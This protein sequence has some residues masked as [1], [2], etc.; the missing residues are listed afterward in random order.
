M[1]NSFGSN[2]SS[3]RR[4]AGVSQETLAEQIGVSRQAVSNW[5]RDLSEP[6]I[7]TINKISEFLH[8]PVSDLMGSPASGGTNGEAVKIRPAL[9]VISV[10]LAVVH[11]VLG[12]CGYV[13][14]F[15]AVFLPVMCAF[16][17]SII[18]IAFTTMIKSNHYDMLA[19]FDPKKDSIPKTQLQMQWIA[20]L[21]G[22]T[23]IL[24]ELVFMPVYFVPAQRQMDITTAM[25]FSYYAAIL[26][27]VI[28]V[29][30]KIKSRT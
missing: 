16:I 18:Y 15:A 29:N 2:L 4:K 26:I 5:E 10:A 11:L 20:V 25:I 8:V 9:T 17:Q 30:V 14:I 6:D 24:F 21:S 1:K 3:L 27:C 13:N 12:I 28:T 19:G 22:L 23:S 7:G